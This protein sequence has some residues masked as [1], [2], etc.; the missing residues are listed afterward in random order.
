MHVCV[1]FPVFPVWQGGVANWGGAGGWSQA[2]GWGRCLRWEPAGSGEGAKALDGPMWCVLCRE[3]RVRLREAC[4]RGQGA[5]RLRADMLSLKL[6]QL[7]D[8]HQVPK[9]RGTPCVLLF[10]YL[11]VCSTFLLSM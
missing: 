6:P 5:L 2:W 10:H 9:V 11:L 7:L 8:T 1:C 3:C 4:E